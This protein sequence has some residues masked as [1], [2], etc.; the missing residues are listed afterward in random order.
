[1]TN[2]ANE[3]NKLNYDGISL[4]RYNSSGLISRPIRNYYLYLKGMPRNP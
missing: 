3:L 1:M 4:F 2:D